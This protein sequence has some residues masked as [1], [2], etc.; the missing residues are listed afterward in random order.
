MILPAAFLM[1]SGACSVKQFFPAPGTATEE[2]FALVRVDSLLVAIRPQAYPGSYQ[3][4]NRR[5]F[6]VLIRVKNTSQNKV[7]LGK[8]SFA[9]IAEE[10]Q[11]DPIPAEL[12]LANMRQNQLLQNYED[13]F[14]MLESDEPRLIPDNDQDRYYELI[15]NSFSYG[16]LLPG[17]MKEGYLFYH[18]QVNR[19]DSFSIDVLGH[20]VDFKR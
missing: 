2:R 9:I 14:A 5:F 16:E 4:L 3:E 20:K 12:I 1:L 8:G 15:Y 7:Q 13:P 17:G 19:A 11:F 6:P 18:V 10:R